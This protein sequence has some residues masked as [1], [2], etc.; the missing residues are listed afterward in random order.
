MK[1]FSG[2]PTQAWGGET[3]QQRP[4]GRRR[5]SAPAPGEGRGG[6]CQVPAE[7]R[8]A[9]PAVGRRGPVRFASAA[10]RAATEAALTARLS[11]MEQQ[12]DDLQRQLDESLEVQY[13]NNWTHL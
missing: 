12:R 6:R 3:A 1:T 5:K 9:A 13:C 7:G 11:A 4:D 2:T 8:N 10:S